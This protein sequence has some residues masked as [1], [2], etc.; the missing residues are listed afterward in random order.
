MTI[1]NNNNRE[2]ATWVVVERTKAAKKVPQH[3][4]NKGVNAEG[5]TE[6][7]ATDYSGKNHKMLGNLDSARN[8]E[9][10]DIYGTFSTKKTPFNG[11]DPKKVSKE[12]LDKQKKVNFYIKKL[13]H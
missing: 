4:G 5:K 6:L 11:V 12:T 3:P 2:Q 10:I 1:E 7:F 13:K 9:N 8:S